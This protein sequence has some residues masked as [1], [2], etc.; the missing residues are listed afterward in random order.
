MVGVNRM[1]NHMGNNQV[2]KRAAEAFNKKR[3]EAHVERVRIAQ[4][5]IDNPEKYARR[6]RRA[7]RKVMPFIALSAAA[8]FAI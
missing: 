1:I 8:G 4:D 2:K 5:K 7:I 6:N 3:R